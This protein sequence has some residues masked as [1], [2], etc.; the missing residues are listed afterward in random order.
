MNTDIIWRIVGRG[1]MASM[2]MQAPHEYVIMK[3]FNISFMVSGEQ[4]PF[5]DAALRVHVPK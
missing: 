1:L 2:R 5:H 4:K 3:S